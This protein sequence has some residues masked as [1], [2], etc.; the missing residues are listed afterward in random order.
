MPVITISF[1]RKGFS[2]NVKGNLDDQSKER[3]SQGHSS[4]DKPKQSRDGSTDVPDLREVDPSAD[5]P[6]AA[7]EGA[8]WGGLQFNVHHAS[9]AP[10]T[11]SGL[12]AP[13]LTPMQD[14]AGNNNNANNANAPLFPSPPPQAG[15]QAPRRR[16]SRQSRPLSVPSVSREHEEVWTRRQSLQTNDPESLHPPVVNNYYY[17]V[18]VFPGMPNRTFFAPV[19]SVASPYYT[20]WREDNALRDSPIILTSTLGDLGTMSSRKGGLLRDLK[21][22]AM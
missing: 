11:R 16:T 14:T 17:Y 18:A 15:P 6:Q 1:G 10:S 13:A 7:V 8:S 2:C 20:P 4:A 5:A 3:E 21:A 12:N 22:K 9:P 19:Q